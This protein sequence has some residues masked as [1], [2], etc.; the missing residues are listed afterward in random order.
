[1]T[2]LISCREDA[3]SPTLSSE[4][5]DDLDTS[6]TDPLRLEELPTILAQHPYVLAAQGFPESMQR[7]FGSFLQDIAIIVE[8]RDKLKKEMTRSSRSC[9]N[10]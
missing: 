10:G 2:T 7:A 6:T 3:L 4:L 9:V 5:S 1:M 8:E